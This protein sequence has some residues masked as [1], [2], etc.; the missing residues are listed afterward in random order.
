MLFVISLVEYWRQLAN[1]IFHA[2]HT[3]KVLTQRKINAEICTVMHICSLYDGKDA[4]NKSPLV[5]Y[6]NW[7]TLANGM[8]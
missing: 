2:D 8:F 4:T 6:S 3:Q 5:A 1:S 7:H